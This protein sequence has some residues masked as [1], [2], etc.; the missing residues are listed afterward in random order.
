MPPIFIIKHQEGKMKKLSKNRRVRILRVVSVIL[1]VMTLLTG[2]A[3]S[4]AYPDRPVELISGFGAGGAT[5]VTARLIA[6]YVSK[7]WGVP[8][9]VVNMPGASGIIG[10]R[11]VMAARPNGYTMMVDSHAVS[12]MLAATQID[13]PF[14]WDHRTVIARVSIDP[15]FYSS[16]KDAPWKTLRELAD[17]IKKNPKV[18]RYG[19]AGVTAVGTFAIPQFL[20]VNNL[21]PDVI[22]SVAFKSGA[23]VTTAL[24]GGHVD[25]AA[26]QY[27]ETAGLLLAN[28]VNGLA[29]IHR[30]RLP[31]FPDLPTVQEAG[32]PGLNVLGWHGVSGPAGL[33]KEIVAK[34]SQALEEAS[35][36]K[37]F[38]EQAKKIYKIVAYLGPKECWDFIQTEYQRYLPLAIK[39]GMRK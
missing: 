34:W 30:E 25:I 35:K 2:G 14:K 36:D 13:L 12:S 33:D 32:F 3:A 37:A 8:V 21:P 39:M 20:E 16:K 7:K 28:K 26:Q 5:D 9:N 31:E 24:A 17:Y 11:H 38:I 23:E 6:G 15:V 22:S 29:I 4:A 10:A 18:L 19:N 27:S 1:F